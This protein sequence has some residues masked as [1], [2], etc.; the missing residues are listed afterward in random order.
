M[1][2]GETEPFESTRGVRQGAPESPW[3]YSNFIDSIAEE[4]TRRGFGVKVGDR[5]IALLM[6]ADDIV[7]LSGTV[8][9]L[10]RMND[11]V[12]EYAYR[13]RFRLNGDKSAV[14]VFGGD[15]ALK[16]KVEREV[17]QL[18]GERVQVKKSYKYLGVDIRTNSA[19]WRPHVERLM[20]KAR[21]RSSE[22]ALLCR[23]D[24]GL[25]PRAAVAM[26]NAMVRPS[27]EYAGELWGGEIS[28]ALT[29]EVEKVQ[30]D[31]GRIILGIKGEMW[32]PAEL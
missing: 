22:L 24:R 26:W 30:T 9:E 7:L 27:L 19:D 2:Y 10:R 8:E 32:V 18:S 21:T 14:M 29:R 23:R 31:F 13:N 11:V 6:Y 16:D 3:L 4:L 20:S 28:D 5:R 15:R 12:T 25:R 17:W 1:S